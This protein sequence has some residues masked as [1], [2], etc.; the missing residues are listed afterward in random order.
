MRAFGR[1]ALLALALGGCA[2]LPDVD[3]WLGYGGAPISES[4]KIRGPLT[5]EQTKAVLAKLV[6]KDDETDLLARQA[7]LEEAVA[8]TPL[9]PGNEVTLLTDGPETYKA[10][11]EAIEG[12]TDHV[13]LEFYTIDDDKDIGARLAEVLLRKRAQGVAVNLIYDGVG[14]IQTPREYFKRLHDA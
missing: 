6:H 12:A 7:A 10:M 5:E 1:V 9:V 13:H 14:S 2:T 3:P 8:G 11:F 4:T